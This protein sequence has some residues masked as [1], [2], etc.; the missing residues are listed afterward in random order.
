[1]DSID[2][3]CQP[4]QPS[5]DNVVGQTV[6]TSKAK[7]VSVRAQSAILCDMASALGTTNKGMSKSNVHRIGKKV[8]KETAEEVRKSLKDKAGS[9][10]ILH[11]DTK[12]VKEFTEGKKLKRERLA[13]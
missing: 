12:S 11:Y 4:E 13:L 7:H 10:M 1:M 9:N 6:L 8:I 3:E 2:K 5:V